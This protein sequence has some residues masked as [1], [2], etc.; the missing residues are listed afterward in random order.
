MEEE[1]QEFIKLLFQ[2]KKKLE[3]QATL[4]GSEQS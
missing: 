4:L 3:K 1:I 2:M